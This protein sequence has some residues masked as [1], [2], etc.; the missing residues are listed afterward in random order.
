MGLFEEALERIRDVGDG[1][2]LEL[3]D[4][5]MASGESDA[6]GSVDLVRLSRK[7]GCRACAREK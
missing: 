2:G 3:D 4:E 7:G 1:G 5:I 6:V